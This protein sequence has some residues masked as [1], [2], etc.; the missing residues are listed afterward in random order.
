MNLIEYSIAFVPKTF[1]HS[2][3]PK[4]ESSQRNEIWTEFEMLP[5][6]AKDNIQIG[7]VFISFYFVGLV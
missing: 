1:R 3:E 5:M 2:A 4:K 7:E 6:S